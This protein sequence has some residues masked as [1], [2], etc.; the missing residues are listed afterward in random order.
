MI[1]LWKTRQVQY[2]SK[3]RPKIQAVNCICTIASII[4]SKFLA[5]GFNYYL[6]IF[7]VLGS[8]TPRPYNEQGPIFLINNFLFFP[9]PHLD[10]WWSQKTHLQEKFP[11][12][13]LL[14][15]DFCLYALYWLQS[16]SRLAVCP[17]SLARV[18]SRIWIHTK[19]C[20]HLVFTYVH[21]F[22]VARRLGRAEKNYSF[23]WNILRE[24]DTL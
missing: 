4:R 9:K 5:K 18:F 19:C 11:L 7:H 12:C 1:K 10:C 15:I 21:M 20:W 22:A 13:R 23:A 2:L 8:Q 17:N 16:Q 24:T 6:F 3:I 14:Q